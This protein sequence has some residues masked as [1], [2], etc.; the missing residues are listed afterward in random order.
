M[1]FSASR[2]NISPPTIARSVGLFRR[3]V[4]RPGAADSA[5]D[6]L[7][8]IQTALLRRQPQHSMTNSFST[9]TARFT[10]PNGITLLVLENHANPTV[11]VT[12]YLKAGA[13]FNPQSREGLA[14]LTAAM[15]NKG[16]KRRSK[17]EIAEAL[18]F[19]GAH[20]GFSA[21]TF[22][23]GIDAQSLSRDF[24]FVVSTLAEELREPAFP[25]D[26]LSKLKQRTIASIQRSQENTRGRAV[27]R[28]T[29][30][31][32]PKSSPF[33]E[34]PAVE[35]ISQ[36]ENITVE[37]I[38]RFYKARYGAASMILSVVGDVTAA[39]VE[40][41]VTDNLGDWRG[42]PAPQITVKE[43][44]LQAEPRRDVVPMK[45]KANVDVV[46]GH[47]SG[48]RRTNPD[49]LAAVLA[50]R[51]LGQSTISSRLGLKVR[52]EMGLTYGINSYFADSGLGDGPY[53]IGL[54]LAPQ[55]IE[56][57]IRTT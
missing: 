7:S 45:D 50:N 42:A 51:A 56:V 14:D 1:T 38:R 43:T 26:E 52:D 25:T 4:S 57:G 49:Y 17:L 3:K 46:I 53:I 39:G 21:N 20:V 23:V 48:L 9:R 18:E 11:S 35:A 27:E 5:G 6:G 28:L 12:G 24:P 16:T 19:A 32:F 47:A 29:Q 37:D 2:R 54:T 55:D 36:V 33:Y 31:I 10:L 8:G 15:L 41:L 13:F 30:I 34:L 22:T 40:K 44:P